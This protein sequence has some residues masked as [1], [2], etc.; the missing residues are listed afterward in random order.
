MDSSETSEVLLKLV[1]EWRSTGGLTSDIPA[2]LSFDDWLNVIA[3]CQEVLELKFPAIIVDAKP[4]PFSACP[5][6][7]GKDQVFLDNDKR[8]TG[9]S[10]GYYVKCSCGAEGAVGVDKAE[11]AA[12]WNKRSEAPAIAGTT[13]IPEIE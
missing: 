5:F 6:C 2:S 13:V 11:A 8:D 12:L 3:F 1:E 9:T 10:Y 4:E 7:G